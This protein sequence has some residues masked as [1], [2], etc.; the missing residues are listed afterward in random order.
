MS[1]P[2]F[3][4]QGFTSGDMADAAA[5]GFQAGVASTFDAGDMADQGASQFR[6]GWDATLAQQP[7]QQE[8][9]VAC[10]KHGDEPKQGCGW[11]AKLPAVPPGYKPLLDADE[12]DALRRFSIGHEDDQIYEVSIEMMN[13][14]A[15][16]GVVRNR[17]FGGI[18]VTRIG[19]HLLNAAPEAPVQPS[20]CELGRTK[21]CQA[22]E[23]GCAS[24]CPA[25]PWQPEAPVQPNPMERKLT[26]F[27]DKARAEAAPSNCKEC[28]NADSWGLPD[29]YVC[30]S[31][32]AGSE[33]TPLNQSSV[34]PNKQIEAPAAQKEPTPIHRECAT[35]PLHERCGKC[36]PH[37]DTA[38]QQEPAAE[39]LRF[40][41]RVLEGN[42]PPQDRDAAAQMVRDMR[43]SI[44]TKATAAQKEQP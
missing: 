26:Y 13:R 17:G 3:P 34:N 24:E 30:R 2:K 4:D 18:V 20:K 42:A 12:F 1:D 35:M 39:N 27:E 23:H 28:R 40:I 11:C 33:W 16:I 38:V 31:C 15:D 22:R 8:Q 9:E 29:K 36:N 43:R 41:Q 37:T 6:A 10:Y 21:V 14:L 7:A 25:L 5:K 44:L 19:R 32:S